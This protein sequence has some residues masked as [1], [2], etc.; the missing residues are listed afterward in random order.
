MAERKQQREVVGDLERAAEHERQAEERGGE[1]RAGD[2]GTDRGGKA[3]RHRG[4]AGR[5]GALGGRTTAI[6]ND[7]RVGTSICEKAAR[8]SRSASTTGR[9]EA[10][11]AA[12]RQMLEGMWVNTMVLTSPNRAPRRAATG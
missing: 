12:I 7:V 3:P 11:A 9:L 5:R 8:S 10:N 1:E 6:T 4:D 2:R